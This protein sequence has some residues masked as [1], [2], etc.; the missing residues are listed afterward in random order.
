MKFVDE[1]TIYVQAGKGGNGCLSFRR[2]KYLPKGGPDG[3]DGGHGGSVW[4]RGEHNMNTL[5]DY[6]YQRSYQAENGQPGS[7]SNCTGKAGAEYYLD[8]PVGTVAYD[9]ASGDCIGEIL[10]PGQ[11]LLVA[12]GGRKG[13][14]NTRF[15]SSTNQAPRHTTPGEAGEERQLRLE[16]RL[17]ADV[18][19]L[20]L[21]N[22]GK[23]TL[24]RA[25]SAATPRVADYP[26]TTMHPRLGVVGTGSGQS[27]V[28]ADIPG[29]IEGASAGAG[30]G[31]KF[32]KH[33][34]R[35]RIILHLVDMAP[36]DDSDPAAAIHKVE[37]EL[38]KYSSSL[39]QRE[40]WLVLNK[41]DLMNQAERQQRFE[42]IVNKLDWPG[43]CFMISSQS[44]LGTQALCQ[45]LANTLQENNSKGNH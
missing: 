21:P 29:V 17:L 41:C 26:F 39:Y 31:L 38:K 37:A 6:R 23:S 19:L 35:T 33:L 9:V 10:E 22:A 42:A 28:L 25:V 44:G 2:E 18:G 7:G 8:V 24:I 45:A 12:R 40:R 4:L 14:G 34:S 11:T 30:L 16:M 36:I 32:L 13:L 20:G 43:R 3:G 5:L 27:F 15:K 1:A